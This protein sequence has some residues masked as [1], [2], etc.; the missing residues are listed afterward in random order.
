[1]TNAPKRL[2]HDPLNSAQWPV[3]ADQFVTPANDFFIRSHAPTPRVDRD[4]WRLEVTGL[5][6]RPAVF[7]FEELFR[8]FPRHE[9]TA[10]MV[11]AGLR[12]D[13]FLSIGPLPGELPWGP[14]PAS[15]G[16]W[17]GVRLRDVLQRVGV[18]K[19]AKYVEFIG[20]DQVERHGETFGFGGSIDLK[21]ALGAEVLLASELNGAPLPLDHGFPV[22]AVVPGW[23][24]ARSV[25]W[26]GKIVLS[27]RP[28]R[29]YFQT[30]AYRFQRTT[31]PNDIRD[32]THGSE[33][34]VLPL[35]AV[36]L[37]P[38]RDEVIPSGTVM[39]RGWAMGSAGRQLRSIE[40]SA[41]AGRDWSPARTSRPPAE[42]S[43]TFW[44]AE[45][46]LAPGRHV[47]AARASDCSG[48]RQPAAVGDMW[49]VKG[50]MNNAWHLIPVRAE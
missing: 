13:E 37:S 26:L 33:L 24:G 18:E 4:T 22:R 20:L 42:W 48:E 47:L 41:N 17:A 36:I 23:I 44:E 25:K 6:E 7:S 16:A 12:R 5:V 8:E 32:V 28:S 49:N 38:T 2:N 21:K 35:N 9:V 10:T 39:V 46:N 19:S 31:N 1:M 3:P 34:N 50:Y 30:K 11:C 14:E 45:L 29:N 43:W 15:N 27:E 40:V